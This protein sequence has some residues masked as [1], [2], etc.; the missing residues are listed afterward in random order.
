MKKSID[1]IVKKEFEEYPFP[2]K[3]LGWLASAGR[4]II[5]TTQV[6]VFAVLGYRFKLDRQIKNLDEIVSQKRAS[7]EASSSFEKVFRQEQERLLGLTNILEEKRTIPAKTIPQTLGLIPASIDLKSVTFT[8]S[9][10]TITGSAEKSTEI[11]YLIE[12]IK[13]NKAFERIMLTANSYQNRD[14]IY[15]FSLQ[16]E[17]AR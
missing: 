12:I 1:L 14:K 8:T 13:K 5:I 16:I 11:G 4:I 6:I 9:T 17:L 7:L 2:Q 15:H 10:I 3:F